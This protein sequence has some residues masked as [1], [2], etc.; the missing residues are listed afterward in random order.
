[1]KCPFCQSKL[2]KVVD[3]RPVEKRGEIRRRRECLKCAKR[4]TTY[5]VL[6]AV[7]ILVFF[8][9][10]FKRWIKVWKRGDW[11]TLNFIQVGAGIGLFV[12]MLHTFVDFN[13]HIPA[14]QIYFAFL[15]ALFFYQT[16]HTD[17]HSVADEPVH[18]DSLPSAPQVVRPE[19]KSFV[20]Q[21][22]NPF[23]Q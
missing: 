1:M 16:G 22:S 2:S 19:K 17:S 18:A 20:V 13:L 21:S 10:Y 9:L 3:K 11:K 6:A 15:A 5:E 8:V 12:M 23:S 7:L 4:F 14:N